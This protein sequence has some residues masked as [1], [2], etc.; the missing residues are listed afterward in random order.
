MHV[1]CGER[2]TLGVIRIKICSFL[3]WTKPTVGR[4]W[5][6]AHS[7]IFLVVYQFGHP[8]RNECE[9]TT[10]TQRKCWSLVPQWAFSLF[11]LPNKYHA[12]ATF[13]PRV[14]FL[15]RCPTF[16]YRF[17]VLSH[18]PPMVSKRNCLPMSFLH[19]LLSISVCVP[20]VRGRARSNGCV[21]LWSI[22]SNTLYEYR[23][24]WMTTL[25]RSRAGNVSRGDVGRVVGSRRES[26][27]HLS[28][29]GSCW[30]LE[31]VIV[32]TTAAPVRFRCQTL[33]GQVEKRRIFITRKG[34]LWNLAGWVQ[35]AMG[36][37]SLNCQV[38]SLCNDSSIPP[39][40]DASPFPPLFCST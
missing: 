26:A 31:D 12:N 20:V 13:F 23:A 30:G 15:S 39:H 27:H 4:P 7:I 38:R 35:W 2:L 25:K 37:V 1:E 32:N 11:P 18:A 36:G 33:S 10:G 8:G 29:Q 40:L 34:W 28:P 3:F 21:S 14:L 17:L 24:L 16:V 9:T 5:R 19:T 22:S 6:N